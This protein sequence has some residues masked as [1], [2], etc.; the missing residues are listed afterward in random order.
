[1]TGDS[2]AAA[3]IMEVNCLYIVHYVELE[4]LRVGETVADLVIS[5]E[6]ACYAAANIRMK[7]SGAGTFKPLN[8]PR[9]RIREATTTFC[10]LHFPV[11]GRLVTVVTGI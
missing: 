1:V 11:Y 6:K 3:D 9:K 4:E 2:T 10:S 7:P 5:N 8:E